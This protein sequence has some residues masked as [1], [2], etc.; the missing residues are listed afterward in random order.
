VASDWKIF[1]E[2]FKL[3]VDKMILKVDEAT[4]FATSEGA[5]IIVQAARLGF[6]G[7]HNK[8]TPRTASGNRPQS[9]TENLKNS[10]HIIQPPRRVGSYGWQTSVAP[11]MVYSRRIELGFTGA[12]SLGRNYN[13]R[14]YPYL[15]PGV[16]RSRPVI[17]DKF[18]TRWAQAL[19]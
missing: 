6:D 8:G 19:S 11:T 15:G 4:R 12:D 14:P 3:S 10:I 5:G 7:Q 13:Q 1:S 9:I 17:N 18:K 16:E 2:E